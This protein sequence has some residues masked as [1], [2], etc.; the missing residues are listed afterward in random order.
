MAAGDIRVEPVAPLFADIFREQ[1]AR[2][3]CR[4][5]NLGT[6]G[7]GLEV[8]WLKE[9]GDALP[10]KTSLPVL[11]PN[12]LYVAEG[13]ATVGTEAWESGQI[14]TCRVTHPELL[15]PREVPLKKTTGECLGVS[16]P[17]KKEIRGK[18][19]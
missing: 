15:F 19:G 7:E 18:I 16:S 2:L 17:K 6:A 12:G 3:T 9:D 11:Q 4:V 8:T 10:T 14:F 5:S 1:A 13:V